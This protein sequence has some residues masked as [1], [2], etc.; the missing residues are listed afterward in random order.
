MKKRRFSV[1]LRIVAALAAFLLV[2]GCSN[3]DSPSQA[4]S[5]KSSNAE[6]LQTKWLA[7]HTF[8]MPD[9][10]LSD[11]SAA[12]RALAL[13]LYEEL[14]EKPPV[15]FIYGGKRFSEDAKSWQMSEKATENGKMVTYTHT[16]TKLSVSLEYFLYDDASAVEWKVRIA[17]GG[18]TDS[19][20][21]QAFYCLSM[22]FPT[23]GNTSLMYSNG[24]NAKE[25][26]FQPVSVTLKNGDSKWIS[27][28]GGRSSSG[29]MPFFNLYTAK[30]KGYIVAIGWSG[31][32]KA[33]IE[34]NNNIVSLTAGMT[35]SS[36]YLH[37]GESVILPSM[38]MLPWEGD[39]QEG[40]NAL[41]RYIITR[42]T[43]ITKDNKLTIGPLSYGVWGGEGSESQIN[44]L[45]AITN[46]KLGYDVFWID[47]G[48]NG[49]GKKLSVNTFDSA[50]FE[51]AGTWS[52]I[53]SLY[54][55][56]IDEVAS[57]VNQNNMGFLLWFEPERAFA[58]TE[59]VTE[60]PEWFLRYEGDKNNFLFNLG[61]DKARE[62]L[63]NYIAGL[64]KKYGVQIYRQ[65]F[66]MEPLEYWRQA[67]EGNRSGVTEMKYIE[68]LYLY[69]EGL[70]ERCPGLVI[71]NCASGGRRLDFESL[72]RTTPLFR[73]DYQCY[74]SSSTAEGCQMQ[75]Y[76]LNFWVPLS[77]A[78]SMGRTDAYNFRSNY[79]IAIQTPNIISKYEEQ[80]PLNEEFKKARQYFY[81]DY[82]PLIPCTLD[83]DNWFAYQMHRSDLDGGF[84]C[85]FRRLKSEDEQMMLKLSGLA[86]NVDY[87]VGYCDTGETVTVSGKELMEDGLLVTISRTKE[88]AMIFY[89]K[90]R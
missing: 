23:K 78:A 29:T 49:D 48:W 79:G 2:A 37:S 89:E 65:D 58:G 55:N 35:D 42:H 31:Q 36:F 61:N 27:C 6:G 86:E 32:W 12:N 15:D 76:G 59:L 25:D 1:G 3:G 40:H 68:G 7:D 84:V 10:R 24:A 88:S 14:L 8:G 90:M 73:S 50:W 52:V 17:N 43:P 51:N 41:R 75:I 54:P 53:P 28:N 69:W 85:A 4:S 46:R 57:L 81:G 18:D 11:A 20:K 47:A 70:L 26:D 71:D 56:G 39:A 19:R 74:T 9:Y 80:L 87:R 44:Q 5:G 34:K 82:Y 66:N 13:S 72:S 22:G 38:I 67:D 21:I 16:E 60:H 77:G 83:I 30:D 45:R 33:T 64:I 63:C 62:W